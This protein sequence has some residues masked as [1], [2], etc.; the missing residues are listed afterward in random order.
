MQRL[1]GVGSV[2]FFS[3]ILRSHPADKRDVKEH[4]QIGY[5]VI[6]IIWITVVSTHER[7]VMT[8]FECYGYA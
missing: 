4:W 8:D 2:G 7:D 1:L 3:T 5:R 6:L